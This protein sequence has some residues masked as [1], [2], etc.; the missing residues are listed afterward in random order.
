MKPPRRRSTEDTSHLIPFDK[1]L[2]RDDAYKTG[3]MKSRLHSKVNNVFP[4]SSSSTSHGVKGSLGFMKYSGRNEIRAPT[5]DRDMH[6]GIFKLED[7]AA[8]NISQIPRK[9]IASQKDGAY[10]THSSFGTPSLPD[11]RDYTGKQALEI[12]AASTP[13]ANTRSQ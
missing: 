8:I 3:E 6:T 11:P 13:W 9:Y 10:G 4:S 7:I 1:V 2:S 5:I 12:W